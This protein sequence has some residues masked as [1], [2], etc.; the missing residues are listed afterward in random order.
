MVSDKK[1]HS[2]KNPPI[3]EAVAAFRFAQSE[4]WTSEQLDSLQRRLRRSYKGEVRQEHQFQVQVQANFGKDEASSTASSEPR[5]QLLHAANNK[6][7]VGIGPGLLTVHVLK[8][9]PGWK[10]F[11]KRITTAVQAVLDV[12][13]PPGILEVAIR[14]IDR[15]ALPE[16]EGVN[17]SKYFVAL[18]PKPPA[19][20]NLLQAFQ[21]ITQA[22]DP[23]TGTIAVLTTAVVPPGPGESFVMLYDLNM[24]RLFEDDPLDVGSWQDVLRDLHDRQYEVFMQSI[25][26][27]TRRLFE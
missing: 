23:N 6:S 15:I 4:P 8:P 21:C 2:F 5:R 10:R 9:Y 3:A 16:G 25:T 20:P 18:P 26:D 27:D 1:H 24:L 12:M 22:Q 7:L 19:M 17:L 13:E 11:E 14:Y